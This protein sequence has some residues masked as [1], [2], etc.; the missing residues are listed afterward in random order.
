MSSPHQETS[1]S[2][3][4]TFRPWTGIVLLA[5]TALAA[6]YLLGDAVVRA[7]FAQMMLLAP[8]VL[9]AL[10]V[11]YAASAASMLRVSDRGAVVQNLLR[12]TTFGWAHV[13]DV[14]FRWQ[15]EF[16]LD[17][18]T[19]IT[20]MGGPARSRPRR[21]TPQEREVEGIRPPTGVR[22]LEGV[23]ERWRAASADAD[24]PIRRGWDWPAL[25]VLLALIV[26]AATAV[27]LT[28]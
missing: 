19:K 9:F 4:R 22:E 23:R 5:V 21:Q 28:R 2:R 25:A 24:A 14:D 16:H 20:A 6:V 13:R 27:A 3:P 11:M 17:D 7:G 15:M 10:W 26:W 1:D 8:W 12:R 18:G